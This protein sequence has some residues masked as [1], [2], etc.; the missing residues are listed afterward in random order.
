[1]SI[2]KKATS[3][4]YIGKIKHNYIQK[5][6]FCSVLFFVSNI[7]ANEINLSII[8]QCK[9]QNVDTE[10]IK[11]IIEVESKYQQ[12]AINVNKVGSFTLKTKKEAK[13]LADFYIKQGYSVDIGLMQFN[14]SNLKEFSYSIDEILEPCN[15]IKAGSDIFY[16][17]YESTDPNL[18][19][20]ERINKALSIY[21]TGNQQLGFKNGY[22]AKF[23]IQNS[24]NIEIQ[25]IAR[26]SNTK[27]SLVFKPYN[28]TTKDTK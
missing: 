27:L 23:D 13:A 2:Y 28:F 4:K 19:K 21:N 22:V 3:I 17:A 16:L 7:F 9:N 5:I 8:D 25:K 1:M 6:L 18:D 11:Q 14:S 12:F 26:Q 10:I 15:N 20:N 24:N